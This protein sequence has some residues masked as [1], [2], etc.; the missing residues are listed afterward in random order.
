MRAVFDGARQLQ[1]FARAAR[2]VLAA[3]G[4]GHALANARQQ[5]G[6]ALI[7]IETAVGRLYGDFE[8]HNYDWVISKTSIVPAQT[9]PKDSL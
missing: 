7:D 1:A 6:F 9:L 5:D 4:H 3:I 8:R 2:A